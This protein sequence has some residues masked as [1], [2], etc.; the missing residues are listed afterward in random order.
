MRL[1]SGWCDCIAVAPVALRA[2]VASVHNAQ[3]AMRQVRF[4][5]FR[6]R[7]AVRAF[8]MGKGEA[9]HGWNARKRTGARLRRLDRRAAR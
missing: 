6:G 3:R 9:R 4:W 5:Y 8:L 1:I 7:E 2:A